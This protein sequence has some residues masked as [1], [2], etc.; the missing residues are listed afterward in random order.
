ME[1]VKDTAFE[2]YLKEIESAFK[3]IDP[4]E[5]PFFGK[6]WTKENFPKT[7]GP[8]ASLDPINLEMSADQVKE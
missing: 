5:N 1:F 4:D 7:V 8:P 2:S 3:S 6:P